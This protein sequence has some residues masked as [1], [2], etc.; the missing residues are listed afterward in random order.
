MS[1]YMNKKRGRDTMHN[2]MPEHIKLHCCTG[3]KLGNY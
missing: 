1:M 3:P 2:A